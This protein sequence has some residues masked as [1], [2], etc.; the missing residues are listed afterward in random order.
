M[1]KYILI[2]F[3][4]L[5]DASLYAHDIHEETNQKHPA[6]KHWFIEKENKTHQGSFLFIK[7]GDVFI[8]KENRNI[9]SFPYG[10]L[11]KKDQ[12]FVSEKN[13]WIK[14]INQ[15]QTSS[16]YNPASD[17]QPI[18]IY[19]LYV[20]IAI[21]F[22]LALYVLLFVNKKNR[23]Y[24]APLIMLGMSAAIFGFGKKI[25]H[26]T[27]SATNPVFI[28]SAFTPFK[29]QVNTF[30]NSTYFYV[31]SK[32][33]PSTHE[34]MVGISDHGWQQQV[35]IPQ[36]YIGNNAW[37]IPLNP[38]LSSSPI[39]VDSI[40]FTRGA[41]AL[42]I[43]GIPIFNP[44][45]NT[46]VDSYLDGQLDNFGGHCGRA[47]DYHY[48][49]APLHLYGYTNSKSPIAFGLDGFAVYGSVEPDGSTMRSLDENH[50]H[51]FNGVYHYH[52][53]QAAPYMIG[54]MA[55]VV[56]EDATH[57]LIPQASAKPVRPALTPLRGALIT[58]CK[59]NENNNGYTLTYTLNGQV[60]S[61]V[62]YWNTTGLYN[63]KFYTFGNGTSTTSTYNSFSQCNIST[64]V[65]D[66]N[67][68]KN[69]FLI[70]P[71][72]ATEK[73]NIQL[74]E[75]LRANDIKNISIYNLNGELIYQHNHF[76]PS[77]DIK[78]FEKGVYIIKVR[79]LK[80]EYT[81]KLIVQ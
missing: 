41:I 44:H 32:G 23:N 63:F 22:A 29:S 34:M 13:E 3:F 4:G 11:S 50:G 25:Q 66:I 57:Q 58:S 47:D 72:P 26:V 15:Q 75:T 55:G 39:P 65:I 10:S 56:T 69:N 16:S 81:Q 8:E 37:P 27:L 59:P 42:A 49:I 33:I 36:C 77:I 45:T 30:W 40:H 51:L 68:P 64:S 52:G 17:T 5:I 60:D 80:I 46:G 20:T 9:I 53:T 18:K 7:N 14:K 70:F 1:K 76:E 12:Q 79:L 31:E 54:R 61:I 28:D 48:H 78:G 2:L 35:P 43:N 19:P 24:L 6:I 62:Y 71:N 74:N 38:V 21:L 73:I 67:V